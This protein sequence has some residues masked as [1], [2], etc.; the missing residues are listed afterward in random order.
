MG[1]E[2]DG[3]DEGDEGENF[4]LSPCHL[5]YHSLIP[6]NTKS[7]ERLSIMFPTQPSGLSILDK[8]NK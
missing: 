3:R 6:G 4:T 1:D 7:P 2:G 8:F 5:T